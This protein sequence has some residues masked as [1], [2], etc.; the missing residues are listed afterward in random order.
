MIPTDKTNSFRSMK[1]KNYKKEVLHHLKERAAPISKSTLNEIQK[2]CFALLKKHSELFSKNEREFLVEKINSKV[3]PTPR[4]LIKDH[5]KM[6]KDGNFDT[7]LVVPATNFT[8]GF[9][10]ISYLGIKSLLDKNGVRYGSRN[11]VQ[12]IDLKEELEFFED[13]IK[14]NQSTIVSIDAEA[15]YPSIKYSLIEKEVFFY[16]R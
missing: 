15:M 1:I 14:K 7:R 5:K 2:Q 8:A 3:I 6:K 16:A 10:K 12:A 4:L 11:I 13:T 9:S